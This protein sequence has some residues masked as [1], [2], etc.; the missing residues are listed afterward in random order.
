[1]QEMSPRFSNTPMW[2]LP[3]EVVQSLKMNTFKQK[4]HTQLHAL[5]SKVTWVKAYK[6]LLL[7]TCS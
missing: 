4:K 3:T 6:T 1:M 7:K 5:S 2:A